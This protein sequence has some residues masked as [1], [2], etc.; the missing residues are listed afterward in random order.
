MVTQTGTVSMFP[1]PDKLFNLQESLVGMFVD[2]LEVGVSSGVNQLAAFALSTTVQWVVP[3]ARF[4][5]QSPG[6][7]DGKRAFTDSLRSD[8][9]ECAGQTIPKDGRAKPFLDCLVADDRIH[10]FI[11]PEY[12]RNSKSAVD[13]FLQGNGSGS[14]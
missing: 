9:E 1:V 3:V 11:I 7:L 6:Q 10:I 2:E 13:F 8:H 12:C 14:G 4:T 5:E